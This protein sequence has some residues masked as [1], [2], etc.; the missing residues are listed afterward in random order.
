MFLMMEHLP[1]RHLLMRLLYFFRIYFLGSR[2]VRP[3][4]GKEEKEMRRFLIRVATAISPGGKTKVVLGS[5]EDKADWPTAVRQK[6]GRVI[7]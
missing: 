2:D 7:A 4:A 1:P 5:K 3:F 6:V